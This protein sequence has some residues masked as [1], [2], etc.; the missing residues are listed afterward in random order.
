MLL[1][2]SPP[3]RTVFGT[4]RLPPHSLPS[5][6]GLHL[7]GC[8]RRR[9]ASM[10]LATAY[11]SRVRKHVKLFLNSAIITLSLLWL[12]LFI[13][14]IN[15]NGFWEL[16]L[17]NSRLRLRCCSDLFFHTHRFVHALSSALLTSLTTYLSDNNY[18]FDTTYFD[19][20]FFLLLPHDTTLRRSLIKLNMLCG[21]STVH[22]G[23]R[24]NGIRLRSTKT[25]DPRS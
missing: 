18:V 8:R 12:L 20:C 15:I 13:F 3:D 7:R 21:R 22:P 4:P 23:E 17:L 11:C 1:I 9:L 25:N 6:R 10:L 19:F 2:F 16:L 5:S 14:I 24:S